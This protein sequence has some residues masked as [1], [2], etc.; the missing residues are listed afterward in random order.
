MHARTLALLL[1]AGC[2][3]DAPAAE[4]QDPVTVEDAAAPTRDAARPMRDAAAPASPR[5]DAG[6]AP[7]CSPGRYEGEFR[8]VISSLLPW[9]GKISFELVE[10]STNEGEFSTLSIVPGTRIMGSDDS[11]QGMFSADL[12]GSFDC[13]TSTLNGRIENGV[14]LFA[15]FMEYEL[16][17][18]LQGRYGGDGGAPG[19]D[20]TMS[21]TS[22]TFEAFGEL[23]PSA[24]C[25]WS[26]GAR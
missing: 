18:P 13:A 22:P 12:T 8:C 20:G 11:L 26:A 14:Y 1:L 19:F 6:R 24:T 17:G 16:E 15:G 5:I 7:R 10:E 21:L 23:G 3:D 2:S 9:V 4:T 25:T